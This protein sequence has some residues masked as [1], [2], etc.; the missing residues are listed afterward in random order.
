M[1]HT[2]KETGFTEAALAEPRVTFKQLRDHY[3][4]ELNNTSIPSG[5]DWSRWYMRELL[6]LEEIGDHDDEMSYEEEERSEFH[7][8]W[9]ELNEEFEF[10]FAK[11]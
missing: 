2:Q 3:L 8:A 4:T 1:I 10:S 5:D 9:N 11:D 7:K 6:T